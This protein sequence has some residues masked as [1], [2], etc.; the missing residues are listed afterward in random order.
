MSTRKS[1]PPKVAPTSKRWPANP[2]ATRPS[3]HPSPS[4]ASQT[5][6]IEVDARRKQPNTV[7][8]SAAINATRAVKLRLTWAIAASTMATAST[9]SVGMADAVK[10]SP[11]ITP[12]ARIAQVPKERAFFGGAASRATARASHVSACWSGC[13]TSPVEPAANHA[14]AI[15]AASITI[16]WA[17]TAVQGSCGASFWTSLVGAVVMLRHP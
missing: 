15:P 7:V 12:L 5:V 14:A 2:P 4:A 1:I 9:L 11:T 16:A 10:N 6:G 8:P 17:G 13:A 3:I